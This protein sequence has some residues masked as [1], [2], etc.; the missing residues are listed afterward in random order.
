MNRIQPTVL[1]SQLP[2]LQPWDGGP[3]K[4]SKQGTLS[5]TD[6]RHYKANIP[7]EGDIDL[8][9]QKDLQDINIVGFMFKIWLR[10]LPTEIHSKA[11]QD[12]IATQC[13]G[14]R[15]APQLLR[16]ELSSLPPWNYYLICAITWHLS[17]LT[18]ELEIGAIHGG[19]GPRQRPGRWKYAG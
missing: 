1:R 10:E 12:K 17:L 16:D 13:Q 5:I 4:D 3:L 14:A 19:R 11:V 2:I 15:E 8:L 9:E 7:A 6:P 18:H